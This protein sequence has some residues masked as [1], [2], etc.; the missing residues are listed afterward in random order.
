MRTVRFVAASFLFVVGTLTLLIGLLFAFGPGAERTIEHSRELERSFQTASQY[1]TTFSRGRGRLPTAQEFETWADTFPPTPYTSPNGM[2]L[3]VDSF[4]DEALKQFGPAPEKSFLLV[5]WRGEW[6]EYYASWVNR[7][8]LH[9]D[10]SKYY[11]L[12]SQLADGS[13]LIVIALVALIGG[14][15]VW[16]NPSFQQT[17]FGGR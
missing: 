3:Q 14:R 12:G 8:S 15:K 5:Y 17:A 10:Q 6:Y 13:V 2:R 9:F 16:P 7:T 4:P 11:A 1:V